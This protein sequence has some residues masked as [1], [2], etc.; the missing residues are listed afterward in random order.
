[1][2]NRNICYTYITNNYDQLKDP[3]VVSPGW[4]YLCFT[5]DPQT[6]K[7][8]VWSIYDIRSGMAKGFELLDDNRKN[9]FIKMHP[10]LLFGDYEFSVYVDGNIP[11]RNGLET[12]K[13]M[14]CMNEETPLYLLPHQ[15]RNCIYQEFNACIRNMK[16][17]EGIIY[18]QM[19]RYMTEKFPFNYG[20]S[21]NC[22][23]GRYHNNENCIKIMNEWWEQIMQ[24]SYRDQLSLFYVL[25]KLNLK[26]AISFIPY[27]I[28]FAYFDYTGAN[29]HMKDTK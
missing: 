2:K 6:T 26:N 21:H 29:K 25:W 5:D 11:I 10:H 3:E 7:S 23:I 15:I 12:F 18:V 20:L 28:P 14:Y 24:Y 4:D 17:N 16:D 27:Q 1:M 8:N 9:R 22:I 19:K 13:L